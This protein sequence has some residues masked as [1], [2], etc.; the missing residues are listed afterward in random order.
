MEEV[1][2]VSAVQAQAVLADQLARRS[3]PVGLR[4]V[5]EQVWADIATDGCKTVVPILPCPVHAQAVP[6]TSQAGFQ[7]QRRVAQVARLEE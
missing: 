4:G 6:E 1:V 7:A 2:R 5:P 3:V